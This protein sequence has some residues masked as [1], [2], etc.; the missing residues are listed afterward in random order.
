[1]SEPGGAGPRGPVGDPVREPTGGADAAAPRGVGAVLG[2]DFSVADAVG[3]VRG[4]VESVAPGMVF[5]VAYVATSSLTPALVASVAVTLAAVVLRLVQRT[6]VTQA[7]AGVVGVAIGVFW[8]WRS[9]EAQDYF[10]YGLWTNA[11]YLV[12]CVVSVLVGWPL[13]GVVVGLLRGEGTAWRADRTQRR[14]Y[15]LATWVWVAMF[16]VRLVVQVPLYLGASVGWLGTARLVMG[17]PLWALTLWVT[18][19]LVRTPGSSPARSRPP[20]AP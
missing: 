14:R 20:A 18:W 10:A 9:G 12:A 6:P 13:V 17:V 11:A 19:L 3:G 15:A 2:E 8:A 4:L 1:M 7:L 16:G 5:V